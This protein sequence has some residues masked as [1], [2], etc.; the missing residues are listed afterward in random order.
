MDAELVDAF[1]NFRGAWM[2][3]ISQ[4]R[5][6]SKHD[7]KKNHAYQ[8]LFLL[9]SLGESTRRCMDPVDYVYGVLGIL[10]VKI[11]RMT[12]PKAVWQR[13]LSELDNYMDMTDIK[14]AVFY[15]D[16]SDGVKVIG[17]QESAYE[18]DLQKAECMRYVYN[19]LLEEEN[20]SS[21]E[22]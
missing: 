14:S 15:M 20:I 8:F 22:E 19:G 10:N 7:V 12:D 6:F 1:N 11:P 5:D 9:S 13:F 16:G 21:D 18:I 3:E 2:M 4:T 17:I